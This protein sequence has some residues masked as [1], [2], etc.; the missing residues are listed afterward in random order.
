MLYFAIILLTIVLCVGYVFAAVE[1][2]PPAGIT[3]A[4]NFEL[5]QRTANY[6]ILWL[7]TS[8]SSTPVEPWGYGIRIPSG[9][10]ANV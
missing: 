3:P 8:S 10:T 7:A 1:A 6:H 5:T 9:V 2:E 4:G